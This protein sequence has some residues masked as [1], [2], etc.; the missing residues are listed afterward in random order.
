MKNVSNKFSLVGGIFFFL[1]TIQEIKKY[2][3]NKMDLVGEHG[4]D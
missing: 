2:E 1:N 3:E 4:T